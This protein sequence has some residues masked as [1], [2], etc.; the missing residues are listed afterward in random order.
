MNILI[1]HY[2]INTYKYIALT[3]LLSMTFTVEREN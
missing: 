2:W 1:M 3:N